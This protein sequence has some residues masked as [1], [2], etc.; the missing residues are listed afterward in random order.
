MSGNYEGIQN[1]VVDMAGNTLGDLLKTGQLD[2]L[3]QV[4]SEK[5]SSEK[6]SAKVIVAKAKEA[7]ISN[8]DSG[9]D[10]VREAYKIFHSY[11]RSV[12]QKSELY[13]TMFDYGEEESFASEAVVVRTNDVT[14][15]MPANLAAQTTGSSTVVLTWTAAEN[16]LAYNIYEIVSGYA[17][18]I[19]TATAT[20][21]TVTNLAPNTPYFFAV[22]A[23]RNEQESERTATV[24]AVTDDLIPGAPS[25]L[26]AT[27]IDATSIGLTWD[28]G[29]NATGYNVYRDGALV[30]NST[31]LLYVDR[32][33]VQGT[34]YCYTVKGVRGT[35]ESEE[36]SNQACATTDGTKPVPPVAPVNLTVISASTTSVKLVWG[37]VGNALTYNVYQG[38]EMIAT[39]ELPSYTVEGLEYNTEYCFTVTA[40]NE[41]G[42][43]EKSA[44]AC[45]KT[46]GEGIEELATSLNVY[47]NP[48]SDKLY[49]ETEVEIEEVVVYD[50]FG[51]HQV[52]ET[53]SHQ[54]NLTI[55][56]TNLNSGV[57]FV[58]VVT[59]NGEAV[60]RF[61]KK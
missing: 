50:M 28:A 58:K 35:V 54:G 1:L 46:K 51:R 44:E 23:V 61:I 2:L 59:E 24:S 31:G 14:V 3:K 48:V 10:D 52:T 29:E 30:G 42:E 15:G 4:S 34:Q 8:T 38:E 26:V 49:I 57:Y 39:T 22:S 11:V 17:E 21:Y 6:K 25:N 13:D 12:V 32:D 36:S 19:G 37:A 9:K 60:K 5:K 45:G 16:A 33:L 20:T 56:V 53:P 7:S 18:K 43:S 40:V 27:K 55:D 41:V 47:P